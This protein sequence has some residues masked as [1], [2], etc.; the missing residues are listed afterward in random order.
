MSQNANIS[1]LTDGHGSYSI[2]PHRPFPK[3]EKEKIGE[4]IRWTSWKDIIFTKFYLRDGTDLWRGHLIYHHAASPPA[5]RYFWMIPNLDMPWS[6]MTYH[7]PKGYCLLL[8]IR[9]SNLRLSGEETRMIHVFVWI[10]GFRYDV[11]NVW[12]IGSTKLP[13]S[14][15]EPFLS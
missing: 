7:I 13:V 4:K 10:V 1:N 11:L 9:R 12:F 2:I 6:K 5:W 14:K 15:Y 8:W 3:E